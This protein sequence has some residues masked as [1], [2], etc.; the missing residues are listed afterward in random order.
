MLASLTELSQL[1]ALAESKERPVLTVN[2]RE[3]LYRGLGVKETRFDPAERELVLT[4]VIE[5]IQRTAGKGSR[6][7]EPWIRTMILRNP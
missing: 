4:E 7:S 1:E 5:E 2:V 3:A 6:D